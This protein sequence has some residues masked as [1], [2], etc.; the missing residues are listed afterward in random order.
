MTKKMTEA[1]ER[2]L[3]V[4]SGIEIAHHWL[5]SAVADS[6][7]PEQMENQIQTLEVASKV[8]LATIA[9]NLEKQNSTDGDAFLERC[10]TAMKLELAHLRTDTSV[11]RY[12]PGDT[13]G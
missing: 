5:K 4:E 11:R 1:E 8:T 10:L 9:F 7:N 6:K 12:E 2:R 3:I 13:D